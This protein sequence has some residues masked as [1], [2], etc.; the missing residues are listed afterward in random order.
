MQIHFLYYLTRSA[1]QK[2]LIPFLVLSIHSMLPT[3]DVEFP[4]PLDNFVPEFST[5]H[6]SAKAILGP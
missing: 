4:T 5:R 2:M 6:P 3:L 1:F